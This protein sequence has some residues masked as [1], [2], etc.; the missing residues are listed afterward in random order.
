VEV[1]DKF[2][3]ALRIVGIVLCGRILR[4]RN[5][6]K[7]IIKTMKLKVILEIFV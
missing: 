4:T 7:L 3:C 6:P 1:W 2:I 5:S